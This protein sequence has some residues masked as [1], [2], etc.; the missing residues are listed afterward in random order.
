[1]NVIQKRIFCLMEGAGGLERF[2]SKEMKWIKATEPSKHFLSFL[3]FP[4]EHIQI[5]PSSNL[6][7][8]TY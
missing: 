8:S 6:R 7:E 1:M 5:L 4:K 3:L 2:G